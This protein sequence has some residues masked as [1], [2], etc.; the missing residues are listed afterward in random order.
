M[1]MMM[2]DTY[3]LWHHIFKHFVNLHIFLYNPHVVVPYAGIYYLNFTDE[4]TP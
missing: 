2:P 1:V 3:F 4:E